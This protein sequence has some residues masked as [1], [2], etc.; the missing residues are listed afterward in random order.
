MAKTKVIVRRGQRLEPGQVSVLNVRF[1]GDWEPYEIPLAIEWG[2]P[3]MNQE[4]KKMLGA[5]IRYGQVVFAT[6]CQ[7]L[8]MVLAKL[9]GREGWVQTQSPTVRIF[10][11]AEGGGWEI[12]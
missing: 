1:P 6:D 7:Y 4:V 5:D 10:L 11:A 2:L 9:D 8:L 12:V 3:E